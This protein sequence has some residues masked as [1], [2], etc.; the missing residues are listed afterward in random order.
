MHTILDPAMTEKTL[1]ETSQNFASELRSFFALCILNLVFGAL[2]LAFGVQFIVTSVLALIEG[3][4]SFGFAAAQ[5]LAW[6]AIAYL[7]LRWILSSVEV[8]SRVTDIREEYRTLERPVSKEALTGLI[9]R[10]MVQYRENRKAIRLMTIVCTLGGAIFLAMGAMNLVQAGMAAGSG[11]S[12]YL[13]L[14]AAG[15]NLAIGVVALRLSSWFRRYARAW[16]LR[17]AEASRSEDA[18]RQT[19]EQG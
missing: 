3:E 11:G 14:L 6:G 8:M 17:L 1:Q 4:S 15:I 5:I 10:M 2:I 19:M 18:L 13:S 9:I 16:D 12:L 7:G